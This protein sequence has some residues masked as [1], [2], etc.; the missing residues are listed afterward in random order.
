MEVVSKATTIIQAVNGAAKG[1][2]MALTFD[3]LRFF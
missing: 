2:L 1:W 3:R